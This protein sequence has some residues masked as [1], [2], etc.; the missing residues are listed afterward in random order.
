MNLRS[1]LVLAVVLAFI[2]AGCSTP[3]GTQEHPGGNGRPD[4]R[5]GVLA[6]SCDPSRAAA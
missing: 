1:T 4:L 2:A 3:L 6:S 5:F